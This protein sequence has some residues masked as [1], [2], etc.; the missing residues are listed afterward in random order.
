ME[1]LF[2]YTVDASSDVPSR[3]QNVLGEEAASIGADGM[4]QIEEVQK[5]IDELSQKGLLMRQEYRAATDA[6]F[7]RLLSASA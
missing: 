5:K 4:R 7:Y 6:D 1:N 3:V 2:S